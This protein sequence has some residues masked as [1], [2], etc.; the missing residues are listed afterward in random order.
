MGSAT[1]AAVALIEWSLALTLQP[2]GQ[3]VVLARHR[4]CSD[5]L[6]AHIRAGLCFLAD[7]LMVGVRDLLVRHRIICATA[8]VLEVAL[9]RVGSAEA[10]RII[11]IAFLCHSSTSCSLLACAR[12]FAACLVPLLDVAIRPAGCFVARINLCCFVL[13][14]W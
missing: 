2:F 1:A 12:S 13:V 9:L 6:A 14:H 8:I 3:S 7:S 10:G 11:R 5:R 4:T